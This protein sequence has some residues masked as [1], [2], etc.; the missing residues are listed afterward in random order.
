M[1]NLNIVFYDA[2]GGH[3]NAADAVKTA[4]EAQSYPW[5]VTLL[6]LQELLDRIDPV[7]RTTGM[8]IQDVY[9]LILRRGWTRFTP[10]LLPMLQGL[11]RLNHGGIVRVLQKYWAETPSDLVLSVIP[12]FNRQI[13]ESVRKSL[14]EAP[15][16]TMLTD[17]AD[18]PPHFW[19]E[20]E[21]EFLICGTERAK[22]QA[23]AM[24]HSPLRIFETS[25]MVMKSKFY[26]KTL[27]DR[28][29]ERKQLGLA[30][31]RPTGIV[32]FGG[33]GA[34]VMLDIAA[35]LDE[36]AQDLQLIMICGHNKDLALKLKKLRTKKK[37]L[38][39]GFTSQVDYYMAVADFFIGKP[40][41]GSIS[42]ALQFDLPAIVESNA[43][44]MPQERYNT[45]WL[46]EKRLGIVLPSFQEVAAAVEQLLR[47]STFQEFRDN[48]RAHTNRALFEVP[49]ILEEVLE[50]HSLE[51]MPV[52]PMGN[53][54]LMGRRAMLHGSR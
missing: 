34:P 24:G 37:I 3:R 15:F 4:M 6:N 23:L 35:K 7:H 47:P 50:R 33:H 42:E 9:N 11:I 43:K 27:I 44:T 41:P 29:V 1:R 28:G 30:P 5:T 40:G 31:D 25:G 53:V 51:Y 52:A 12:H 48:A 16:V 38:V 39:E 8:R 13:A 19:I 18:Y 2:G 54:D 21:S 26:Q 46:T 20:R 49:V 22:Q 36:S 10:Q 14:P 32:L 45:E 17:L